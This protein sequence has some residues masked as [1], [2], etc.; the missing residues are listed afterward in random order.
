MVRASKNLEQVLK[1]IIRSVKLSLDG[2]WSLSAD[3]WGIVLSK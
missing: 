1:F 3:T 2:E